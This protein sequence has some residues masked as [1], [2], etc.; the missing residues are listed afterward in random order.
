MLMFTVEEEEEA[1]PM[2][3]QCAGEERTVGLSSFTTIVGT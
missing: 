1:D 3:S 2:A